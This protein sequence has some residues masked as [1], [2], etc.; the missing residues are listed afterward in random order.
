VIS[1]SFLGLQLGVCIIARCINIFGLNF[2][3]RRLIKKWTIDMKDLSIV[4]VGGTIRGS[5][6][7]A[8]ILTIEANK[9]NSNQV[10]VIKSTTLGL[11]CITTIVLGGIMP[12]FISYVLGDKRPEQP[13]QGLIEEEEEEEQGRPEV[14]EEQGENEEPEGE[15]GLMEEESASSPKK[16]KGKKGKKQ[17]FFKYSDENYW[18]PFLIYKYEE[19]KEIFKLYKKIMKYNSR[20]EYQG[21]I[22]YLLNLVE[23]DEPTLREYVSKIE[24][25]ERL[26]LVQEYS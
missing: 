24:E 18:R 3:F 6:A 19:R 21:G 9:D 1:L 15:R 8:L 5:V 4:A 26:A 7:F 11:V 14:H 25:G 10:S 23:A 16:R 2:I 12:K 13:Q 20:A 17:G 22:F